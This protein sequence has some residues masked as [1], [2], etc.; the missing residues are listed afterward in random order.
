MPVE[1]FFIFVAKSYWRLTLKYAIFLEQATLLGSAQPRPT[2]VRS[3]LLVK[4]HLVG[5]HSVVIS[6]LNKTKDWALRSLY[7]F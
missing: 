3:V 1:F 5:I 4:I 6:V 7:M 2:L